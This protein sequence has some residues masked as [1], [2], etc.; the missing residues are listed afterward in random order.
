MEDKILIKQHGKYI[1]L[2]EFMR[3]HGACILEYKPKCDQIQV[4]SVDLKQLP[5]GKLIGIVGNS[6][7]ALKH[8]FERGNF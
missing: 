6:Y 2:P 8:N 3:E 1:T 4:K 5:D 7:G